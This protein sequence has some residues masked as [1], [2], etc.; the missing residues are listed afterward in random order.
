[1]GASAQNLCSALA[2]AI[3]GDVDYFCEVVNQLYLLGVISEN[4]YTSLFVS[5]EDTIRR[6][7]ELQRENGYCE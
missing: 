5:A 4:E 7:Y 6:N 3:N 2:H 1:M